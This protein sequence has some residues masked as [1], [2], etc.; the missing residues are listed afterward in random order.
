M[1]IIV[2]LKGERIELQRPEATDI[3][4][5]T[6]AH[7]IAHICRYLGHTYRFY[8]VAEHSVLAAMLAPPEVRS[9]VLLHDLHEAI[10]GDVP[11]PLKPLLGAAFA[12]LEGAW[13]A[14]VYERFLGH[15]L[16]SEER[17]AIKLADLRALALERVIFGWKDV[18]WWPPIP[19]DAPRIPDDD[20]ARNVR[21]RLRLLASV[22]GSPAAAKSIF[23]TCA[24]ELGV[25]P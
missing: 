9:L 17:A 25:L 11:S 4:L 24:R 6:L 23:L 15:R 22:D 12:E 13:E 16:D 5:D 8:S 2:G 19:V 7:G 3:S 10:V 20:W 21:D 14:W 1:S 18:E